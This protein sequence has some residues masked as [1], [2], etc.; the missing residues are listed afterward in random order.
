[1]DIFILYSASPAFILW[2]GELPLVGNWQWAVGNYW[3]LLDAGFVYSMLSF[4]VGLI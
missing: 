1:M 2:R 4:F 3:C